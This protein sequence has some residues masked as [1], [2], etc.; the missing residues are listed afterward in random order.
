LAALELNGGVETVGLERRLICD[1]MLARLARWLRAA[2]YDTELAGA[3]VSDR[4]LM[5][6]ARAEDLLILS[7]D[8]KLLERRGAE[9]SV[10]L[11]HSGRIEEQIREI[12]KPLGIDWM[13]APFSRCLQCNTALNPATSQQRTTITE[14]VSGQEPVYYCPSCQ[15]VYWDGSHVRRIGHGQIPRISDNDP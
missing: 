1:G 7:R 4:D 15:Q 2:G 13:K 11:I 6:K 12:T 14:D 9:A 10:F 3:G 5:A 8:R